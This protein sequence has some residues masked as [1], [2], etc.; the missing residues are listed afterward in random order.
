MEGP[1]VELMLARKKGSRMGRESLKT[2]PDLPTPFF[3]QVERPPLKTT[4][5]KV[6][7]F[8]GGVSSKF[9]FGEFLPLRRQLI[10]ILLEPIRRLFPV[11]QC[12]REHH[13][14]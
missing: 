2:T 5:T 14:Y 7:D 8:R 1:L 9:S 12:Q 13:S 11:P 4:L 10:S 3:G 6:T